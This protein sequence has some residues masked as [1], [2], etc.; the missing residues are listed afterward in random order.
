MNTSAATLTNPVVSFKV[1]SG[2]TCDY[3]PSGWKHSQSGTTCT[4][5]PTKS[6]SIASEA[7]YTLNYSTDSSATWKAGSIVEPSSASCGASSSSSTSSSS[8]GS[9]SSSGTTSSSSSS[10]TSSSSSSSTS[11]SS[12]SSGS[13]LF[14][15]CSKAGGCVADCSPP[16]SDPIATGNPDYD[17]YDGC[18]LAAMEVAGLTE[19]WMGQLLKAQALNES[20]ITPSIE[21]STSS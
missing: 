5:T 19:P 18:I 21:K 7:S 1:P 9:S 3:D 12:G 8:T 11:S 2:V 14:A 13:G 16:A 4:Y 10:S 17:L 15:N 20:G 6:L